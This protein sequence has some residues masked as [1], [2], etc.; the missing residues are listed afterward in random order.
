MALNFLT[1]L[2]LLVILP[3]DA[4]AWGIGVHLQIGS[5]ILDQISLL[6]IAMQNI[7]TNHS[8]DFLYGCISADITLGKKYTHHLRNCHSWRMGN[9]ILEA[10]DSDRQRACAYG[11]MA[12]LAADTVAHSYFVPFKMIRTFNTV[13]LKHMYW[14]V[15]VEACVDEKTW[16]LAREIAQKNFNVNDTMMRQV[17]SN[18]IFSFGTNK[19]IFN[20]LLLLNRLQQWQK[21]IR[22]L[23]TNSKWTLPEDNLN[24]Y[25]TLAHEAVFSVLSDPDSPYLQ[26]DPTGARS[27][28]AA[29]VLRKNLKTLWQ[30]GKLSEIEIE[31]YLEELRPR[32]RQGILRQNQIMELL[33]DDN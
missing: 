14:E 4:S 6:P 23:S 24:E 31:K 18:T 7:L 1:L 16:L 13:M 20:S 27:I 22:S 32:F 17:L 9:K 5:Q 2:F 21:M 12:H 28:N 25:L 11:Y 19:R 26:A 15:R 29:H 3:T 10:A 8:Y 33:S 30:S